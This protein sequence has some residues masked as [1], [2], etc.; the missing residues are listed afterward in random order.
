MIGIGE[1]SGL[2]TMVLAAAAMALAGCGFYHWGKPGAD[3][4]AFQRDSAECERQSG[5]AAQRQSSGS[6]QQSAGPWE[7]CMKARGWVAIS[8][9]KDTIAP[10][11]G[12]LQAPK[13]GRYAP[14]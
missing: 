5:A 14:K 6:Q 3:S 10:M 7:T 4:A 13:P 1:E 8:A 11:Q 9:D 2:R 12:G